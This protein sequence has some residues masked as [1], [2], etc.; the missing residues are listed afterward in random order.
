MKKLFISL[1]LALVA[2]FSQAQ[3]TDKI[4]EIGLQFYNLDQF[5]IRYKVGNDK[6]LYRITGISLGANKTDNNNPTNHNNSNHLRLGLRLGFEKPYAIDDKFGF[7]YGL[8]LSGAHDQLQYKY[9]TTPEDNY[10]VINNNL[11]LGVI[12]GC[13]YNISDRIK[14]S[15]EIIPGFN[16]YHSEQDE[17]KNDSFGFSASNG[18]AGLTLGY[19]F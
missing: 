2:L 3:E 6:I 8:E 5:G 10:K 4:H 13:S 7:Y 11:G 16:Y 15:A 12:I 14:L 17:R 1:S 19:V 18:N 9:D